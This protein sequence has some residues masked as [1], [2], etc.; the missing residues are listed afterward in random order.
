MLYS[1]TAVGVETISQVI[2][3]LKKII[4]QFDLSNQACDFLYSYKRML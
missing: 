4:I 3:T 2:S 1:F